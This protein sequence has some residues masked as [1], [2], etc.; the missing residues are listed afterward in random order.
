MK[1]LLLS[2]GLLFSLPL[3]LAALYCK[4]RKSKVLH[5]QQDYV[6]DPRYF[7]NSFR[8]KLRSAL[9]VGECFSFAQRKRIR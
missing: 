7:G 9:P 5:I 1:W 2:F 8:K 3:I 6:R 4:F